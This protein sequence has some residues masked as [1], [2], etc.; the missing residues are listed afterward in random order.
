[1]NRTILSI[2]V[3]AVTCFTNLKAQ[4]KIQDEQRSGEII[5]HVMQRSFYDSNGDQIG[6]LNGL[7][8]KLDYLQDLGITSI[9]LLPLYDA[10][11]YHNYFANDFEKIDRE[12]GSMNDYISLV[13]EIH[14]RGMKIYLD[15]ETQY[16]TD[17]HAWWKSAVG[18]LKSPYSNYILFQDEAHTKPSTI[19]YNLTGLTGYD[20]ADIKITTV[21]LKSREVLDYNVKLFGYFADPN[22]DGKFDDGADGFRLDHAMDNLDNKPALTNLFS[23]FWSPLIQIVK[24]INPQIIFIA[25]QANWADFGFD[26]LDKAKVDRVFA[27]GLGYAILALDKQ[28]IIKAADTIFKM[29]PTNKGQVVFIENHDI[30]RSASILQN[31]INKE[32]TTAALCLLIGGIPSIYY[33][34]EIGMMGK[35]GFGYFGNSDGNDIPRREAFEWTASD[36]G[37]GMA[38][39]YKNSGP[40]WDKTNI[41][42]NDG[43]SLEEQKNDPNSLYNFYKSMLKLRHNSAALSKGNFQKTDNDN[44]RVLSFTRQ[45]GREKT[46]VIVNLSNEKQQVNFNQPLSDYQPLYGKKVEQK[47]CELM[48]YEIRVG[49]IR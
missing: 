26:Y 12:F 24:S 6:D 48:P 15:M 43:I 21:N 39:W 22:K 2:L 8:M 40:W 5:Y 11:C 25:E 41:K 23:D 47:K 18:N 30:D 33:G 17:K 32:K 20:G 7:R 16:V 1:M 49:A 34:Q 3:V 27:F 13:K 37:E 46:L 10:D 14:K 19:I 29:T 28:K 42:P 9:L 38:L 36:S 31:D 4:P 35:G 45:N 44:N